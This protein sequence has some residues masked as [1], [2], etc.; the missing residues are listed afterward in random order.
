MF[1]GNLFQPFLFLLFNAGD[2]AGRALAG[3]HRKTVAPATLFFYS[4]A[5]IL[6]CLGIALCNVVP[7]KPW[8]LPAIMWSAPH[9]LS[10]LL[11]L[12]LHLPPAHAELERHHI[13]YLPPLG[14]L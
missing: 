12:P 1:V 10:L 11:K 9:R 14:E 3:L 2:A 13:F 5:R 7:S 8:L 6:I 4:G